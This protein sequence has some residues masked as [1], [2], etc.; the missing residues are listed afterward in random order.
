MSDVVP[1]ERPAP[2]TEPP[3]P[4]PTLK[5]RFGNDA[6]PLEM[7]AEWRARRAQMQ[8]NW[9]LHEFADGWGYLSSHDLDQEPLHRMQ[10]IES[11]ISICEPRTVLLAR[12]LL[13]MC[14]T[15]LAH[16]NEDPESVLAQGPVLEIVRNVI[17]SLEAM[18]GDM[19]IGDAARASRGRRRATAKRKGD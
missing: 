1:F 10:T 19:P 14:V 7:V 17:T 2:P 18:H 8:K 16:G 15:I 6:W 9:A 3:K 12:E 4:A 13:R 5:D 11:H